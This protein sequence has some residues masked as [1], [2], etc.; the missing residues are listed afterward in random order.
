MCEIRDHHHI[1]PNRSRGHLKGLRSILLKLRQR[2]QQP[3][4]V[5]L[6]KEELAIVAKA[7]S[8]V[9]QYEVK[10]SSKR[11]AETG[12]EDHEGKSYNT[13]LMHDLNE[14]TL[15]GD[16]SSVGSRAY[17]TTPTSGFDE[18]SSANEAKN[19]P[20]KDAMF[21]KDLLLWYEPEQDYDL[22]MLP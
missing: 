22:D 8:F 2:L 17:A 20:R 14:P 15:E 19:E 10:L 3:S 7:E 5:S 12:S 18:H 11:V 16:T 21:R 13:S 9:A 4:Q 1:K 6:K